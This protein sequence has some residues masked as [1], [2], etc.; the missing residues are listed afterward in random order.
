MY[1]AEYTRKFYNVY[2]A[3]EWQRLE[4]SPYGRLQAII[5]EDI[6]KSYVKSGDRILDAGAGPGRF[7]IVAAKAGCRV[8]VL[9]ISD[10]QLEIA[11]K[12][13]TEA[14]K[15]EN[16]EQFTRA[17]ICNLS[18]FADGQFDTVVCFGGALSYVCENR[19]KAADELIR[20]AKPG[21]VILISVMSRLGPVIN[22]AQLPDIPN[23]QNPDGD[24]PGLPGIWP[25]LEKSIL[26]GVYNRRLAME[27]AAMY[28]YRAEELASLFKDC[29]ILETAASNAVI[30][31]FAPVNE[32]L[33]ADPAVWATVVE[34]E[35]KLNHE[36]GLV[37]TGSHIILVVAK[38]PHE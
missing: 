21:G 24:K 37:D 5:H 16:I 1:D 2:G 20:V 6:L 28:L 34:M 3:F 26:T 23:L 11:K 8:T 31:E 36:P 29:L 33:A 30:R 38:E 14:G 13:I 25:V 22:E 12:K 4:A 32:Q 35:K 18:M 7:S 19:Q 17:D 9:D 15:L 10:K 27:H